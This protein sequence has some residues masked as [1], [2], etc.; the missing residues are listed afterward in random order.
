MTAF[1]ADMVPTVLVLT[2]ASAASDAF[3]TPAQ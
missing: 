2:G 3:R 1:A